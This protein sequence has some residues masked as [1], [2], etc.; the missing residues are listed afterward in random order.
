MKFAALALIRFYRVCLSP[1]LPSFCRY[2]P[3]C[4]VYAYEAIE[5]HGM[6]RGIWMALGRVLR[7]RPGGGFGYDPV[8]EEH[9]R[10]FRIK[11]SG[12]MKEDQP[13]ATL[14]PE[15]LDSLQTV[16]RIPEA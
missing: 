9:D 4:S 11:D 12:S 5:R 1:V 14:A 13:S 10:G 6:G 7:C 8:P 3:T 2:Y 15:R 16:S